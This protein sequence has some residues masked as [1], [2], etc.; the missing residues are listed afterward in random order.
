MTEAGNFEGRTILTPPGAGRSAAAARGGGGRGPCCSRRAP[1]AGPARPRRQGPDRVERP[2]AGG[3]WPRPAPPSAGTD[4]LDAARA[5]RRV[6]PDPPAPAGRPLAALVAGRRRGAPP[7]PW[8]RDHAAL[9]RGLRRAWPRPPARPDG[10]TRPGPCADTMLDHFWDDDNGGLFTTAD[11]AEA[12]VVRQ[13]DLLDNATPAANSLA[14]TGLLRLAALTGDA[15]LHGPG[16]ADPP[17]RRR[18][19]RRR[20]D[21]LRAPARPPSTCCGPGSPRSPWSASGPTSW[22]TVRTRY[23]PER[24]AGLGRAV[25]VAAVGGPSPR[26]SL[27]LSRLRL[28]GAGRFGRGPGRS[29]TRPAGRIT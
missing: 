3:R 8:P 23:L 7:T 5:E 11:D 16:R 14:A 18:G 15:A 17:L 4:W 9:G 13:K 1:S 2:H 24:R 25:R 20:P 10:S 28:P 27:R 29:T 19:G 26:V 22:P 12:L 21:R 6:P